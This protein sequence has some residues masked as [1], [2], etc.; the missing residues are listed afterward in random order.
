MPSPLAVFVVGAPGSGKSTVARALADRLRCTAFF[1]GDVLRRTA[2]EDSDT[3]REV[4]A[5]LSRD[6]SMPVALYCR[7]VARELGAGGHP[8][9]VFDGFPRTREQCL[10]IP[11]VLRAAG[12][13]YA[14][15]VGIGL[16]VPAEV[17]IERIGRRNERSED[18]RTHAA[19]RLAVHERRSAAIAETFARYWRYTELDASGRVPGVVA[20]AL[21]SIGA[22]HPARA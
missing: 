17:S 3:G 11:A 2:A 19:V 12:L 1:S 7:I 16:R 21:A 8:G 6:E 15:I 18:T 10:A 20:A 14:R 13:S 22:I 4:A 9:V 5:R